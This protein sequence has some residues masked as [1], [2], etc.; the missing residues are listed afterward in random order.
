MLESTILKA[1]V[2]EET[3]VLLCH[4]K[5]LHDSFILQ[6]EGCLGCSIL[7]LAKSLHVELR[8]VDEATTP[9]DRLIVQVAVALITFVI[10][11]DEL[12]FCDEA[13]DLDDVPH[14]HVSWNGLDELNCIVRLEIS[15]LVFDFTNN[16]EVVHIE[17]ELCVD[18]DLIRDL[19]QSI[20]DKKDV[21]SLQCSLEI[22]PRAV[23]DE[24][25]D[26]GLIA[27]GLQVDMAS[28]LLLTSLVLLV[29]ILIL[30]EVKRC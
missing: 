20:F 27:G 11:F 29:C 3:L 6:F 22:D 30:L 1:V 26:F 13:E 19:S 21:T 14:D 4:S 10:D 28:H 8:G 23:L 18:I 7:H 9:A 12:Y 2:F 5:G 15:N 25:S 17:H 16:S 24:D